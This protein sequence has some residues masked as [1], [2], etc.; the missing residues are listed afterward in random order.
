LSILPSG[1][2]LPSIAILADTQ[3]QPHAPLPD[4]FRIVQVEVPALCAGI[5]RLATIQ[6]VRLQL[7]VEILGTLRVMR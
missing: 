2:Q 1:Q 6:Q 7:D 3:Y 4:M 5:G